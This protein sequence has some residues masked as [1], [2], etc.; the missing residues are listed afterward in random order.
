MLALLASL[1]TPGRLFAA[2]LPAGWQVT[3]IGSGLVLPTSFAFLPDGRIIV[4]QRAGGIRL[5]VDGQTLPDPLRVIPVPTDLERG[6]LGV[7][8]DP[9][10]AQNG[11]VYVYYTTPAPHRNV[12]ARL[13][14]VGNTLAPGET[15]LT[16]QI[17]SDIGTHNGGG[18]QFGPDGFL[19]VATGDGGQDSTKAQNLSSLNGKIL[20]L[21]RDGQPAPGNPFVG[22]PGARAEVFHYGLRNPFRFSFDASGRMFIADVGAAAYEELNIVDPARS[23][24][25]FG[26]PIDEGPGGVFEPPTYWYDHSVFR[27]ASITGGVSAGPGA[28]PGPY[29]EAYFFADFIAGVIDVL[30]VDA[31]GGPPAV[32]RLASAEARIVQFARG[33]D[34]R[35]HYVSLTGGDV[36]RLDPPGAPPTVQV[37]VSPTVV[38]VGGSALLVASVLPAGGNG[39]VVTGDLTPVGGS[40]TETLTDDGTR[41][42][43]AAG[44]GLFSVRFTTAPATVPGTVSLA[45]TVVDANGWR[46]TTTTPLTV[47]SVLDS[48]SDGLPDRCETPFG[49]NP[50]SSQIHEAAGGDYDEDGLTNLAECQQGSHPRGYFRHHFAEGATGA[51][52]TTTFAVANPHPTRDAKVL[53]R[54]L[55]PDGSLT[56]EPLTVPA[57]GQA[58]LDVGSIPAMAQAEF[59]T[60]VEADVDVT[61][62]RTMSWDRGGYGAHSE[63]GLRAP[64]RQWF[65]AEGATHSGFDLFYLLLNPNDV[66]ARVTVTYLVPDGPPLVREIVVEPHARRN[67]WLDAEEPTLAATDVSATFDADLPIVVERAMYLSGGGRFW[68]A[69]HEGAGVTE[70][71]SNWFFA[72]GATGAFFD[73][74]VLLANPSPSDAQVT[75]TYLLPDGAPEI[76]TLTVPARRR[77]TVWVDQEGPR[78]ADTAVSVVVTVTN[79]VP[80]VAERAMWWPGDAA[81]WTEAHDSRGATTTSGRWAIADGR[82]GGTQEAETYVLVANTSPYPGDVRV[83]L[84]F[85]DGTTRERTF[86]VAASSRLNVDVQAEFVDR[87][88]SSFAIVVESLSEPPLALVVE[89]ASYWNAAGEIWAAGANALATPDV[90]AEATVEVHDDGLHPDEIQLPVGGRIRFVNRSSQDVFVASDPEP[91]HSDC[92]AMDPVGQLGPGQSAISGP[93]RQARACTLHEHLRAGPAQHATV[94]IQP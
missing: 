68:R 66:A 77:V 50:A 45:V 59:A 25:N 58:T 40:A 35:V 1:V 52:F 30:R 73:L 37:T 67:I 29:D 42:D 16:D 89:R 55:R 24:V 84:L 72:E 44:D 81:T 75:M 64:A 62:E 13:Q 69:G 60:E 34:G 46:V 61:V 5:I 19:Y 9:Q 6:L 27:S 63:T 7:A 86:A 36:R 3:S 53:F 23:G 54:F 78:L 17:A 56:T 38:E 48:D 76:R 92:R 85:G 71:A 11:F 26:W 90:E 80:I 28:Y 15:I 57:R 33:P 12:V 14:M 21:T 4:T 32:S 82:V 49:L 94:L 87:P 10:F 43:V 79:G 22:V 39:L 74:F 70:P 31:G 2:T 20:R 83:T 51:F 47:Q 18:L 65:L 93:F 91:G 41:G 88:G 8:V